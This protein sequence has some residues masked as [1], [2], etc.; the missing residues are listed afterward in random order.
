MPLRASLRFEVFFKFSRSIS[1]LGKIL[2]IYVRPH[3][4]S[5]AW[6]MISSS[7]A[8]ARASLCINSDHSKFGVLA[9]IFNLTHSLI[10]NPS[11]GH[12][13]L[14]GWEVHRSEISMVI[15][16]HFKERL[17]LGRQK[18]FWHPALPGNVRTWQDFYW[19]DIVGEIYLMYFMFRL[20]T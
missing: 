4:M 6:I 12:Y 19:G 18:Y 14:S 7:M 1:I 9:E 15:T 20:K 5:N 10:W 16:L 3:R 13:L 17:R 8:T 11:C 2:R